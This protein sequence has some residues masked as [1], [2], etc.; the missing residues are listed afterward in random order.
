MCHSKNDPCGLDGKHMPGQCPYEKT[1][2]CRAVFTLILVNRNDEN[3]HPITF[4]YLVPACWA[5]DPELASG[6]LDNAVRKYCRDTGEQ[7]NCLLDALNDIPDHFL[8]ASCFQPVP[9]E[10]EN[11]TVIRGMDDEI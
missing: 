8:Y 7:F 9:E 11:C 10:T 1:C 2:S 3:E 4:K 5:D 6:K